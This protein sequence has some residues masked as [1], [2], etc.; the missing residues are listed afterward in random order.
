MLSPEGTDEAGN[1]KALKRPMHRFEMGKN[2]IAIGSESRE[3]QSASI[4]PR[5]QAELELEFPINR[6]RK[7]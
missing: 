6:I 1:A 5:K 2:T 7:E 3:A 4:S